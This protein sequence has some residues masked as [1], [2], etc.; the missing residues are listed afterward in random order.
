[1]LALRTEVPLFLRIDAVRNC[2]RDRSL[3]IPRGKFEARRFTRKAVATNELDCAPAHFFS[4]L[5][6]L[7][8]AVQSVRVGGVRPKLAANKHLSIP[9]QNDRALGGDGVEIRRVGASPEGHCGANLGRARLLYC[10]Y[11]K[12]DRIAGVAGLVHNQNAVAAYFGG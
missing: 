1:M 12:A 5:Q 7:S 2:H 9:W 4:G 10:G 8:G 3:I 11:R 6:T